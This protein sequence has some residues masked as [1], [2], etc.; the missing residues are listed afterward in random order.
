MSKSTVLVTGV[1]GFLG[2]NLLE[3]LLSE[4]HSVVGIDNLSMGRLANIEFA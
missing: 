1:A 3:R 2:S 4:G